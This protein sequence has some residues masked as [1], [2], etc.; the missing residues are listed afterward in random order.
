M[1]LCEVVS[2]S[3]RGL[4]A[5]MYSVLH[6]IGFCLVLVLGAVLHWRLAMAVPTFLALP[7]LAGIY[8]LRESPSW[9]HRKGKVR[10]AEQAAAFYRLPQPKT[11]TI[12]EVPDSGAVQE[13]GLVGKLKTVLRTLSLQGS[14]FWQNFAFLSL[15]FLLLGWCGFSILSFYAVEVFQLSGSPISA[16]HTS[17]VTRSVHSLR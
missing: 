6:S 13:P 1:Y 2:P 4:A 11:P 9:L 16:A 8:Q 3:R 12:A 14:S 10:E 15:L 17:W 5:A 7:T